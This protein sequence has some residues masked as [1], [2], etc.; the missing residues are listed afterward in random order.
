MKRIHLVHIIPN[1]ELH[2]FHGYDEIIETVRWGLTQLGYE[3]TYGI[4]EI[5]T[6]FTNIIFGAQVLTL[7]T[8][9]QLPADTIIYNLE[10]MSGLKRE[11]IRESYQYCGEHFQIWDYSEFNMPAWRLFNSAKAPV[12]VPIGYAPILSRI[13]KPET[14]EID[15]LFYGGPGGERLRVF[16]DLC[17]KLI[18]TVFVHGLYGKS[19]DSLI[20]NSK[21][22]ININQYPW[23]GIF[24][25]AR[26]SYLLANSKAIVSDFSSDSKIEP[27]IK[28]GIK[29]CPL[30]HVVEEC[31]NL[32]AD[33]AA[34][35]NLEKAGFDIMSKRDIIKI[36]RGAVAC[37]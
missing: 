22:V 31:L 11:E 32:L 19:R 33:D 1:K 14:Q 10:Q 6:K 24:E 7:E 20:S 25:I 16:R 15:V 13:P 2:I 23:F 29:L 3:V 35:A 28:N 37:L 34:R 18:K 36:L 26:A 12:H 21:I 5:P 9:R 27:D 4:N 30:E 17:S 8:L